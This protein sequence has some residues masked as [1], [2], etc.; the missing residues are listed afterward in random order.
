[1]FCGNCGT[2]NPDNSPFCAGCGAKLN[3]APVAP[4][5]PET[6]FA[7]VRRPAPKSKKGLFVGII[8]AVVAVA[9]ALVLIFCLSTPK[10]VAK[11]Y[12]KA[13]EKGDFKAV[14]KLMPK[15][16]VEE[17]IGDEDDQE[18]WI[19]QT[20][21]YYEKYE[22]ELSNIKITDMEDIDEDDL[23]ELQEEFEDEYDLK[24]KKAKEITIEYDMETTQGEREDVE[25][26]LL[27]VKIGMKWY[28]ADMG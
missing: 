18:D 12:I 3:E 22:I 19:E 28:L 10:G 25:E 17:N 21:E 9:V 24:V 27:L 2:Q 7:P 11:K 13:M 6:D 16:M 14:I 4:A 15:A 23:E 1:M 5:A 26:T 8:A 20:E